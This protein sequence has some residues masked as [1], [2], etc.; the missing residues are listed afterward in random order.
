MHLTFNT[1]TKLRVSRDSAGMSEEYV[2][3]YRWGIVD[4]SG[5]ALVP[6]A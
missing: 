3:G 2:G 6:M 5:K 1:R 4:D